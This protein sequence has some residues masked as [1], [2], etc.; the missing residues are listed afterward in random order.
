[1]D[2]DKGTSATPFHS[3]PSDSNSTAYTASDDSRD[4]HTAMLE[5]RIGFRPNLA[6]EFRKITASGDHTLKDVGVLACGATAGN[7]TEHYTNLQ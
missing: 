7:G 5:G 3:N 1:M 2:P 6:F 4:G